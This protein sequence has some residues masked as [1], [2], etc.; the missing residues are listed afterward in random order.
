MNDFVR[1]DPWRKEASCLPPDEL[2]HFGKWCRCTWHVDC[3]TSHGLVIY[4]KLNSHKSN[5]FQNRTNLSNYLTTFLNNSTQ[6]S[7][8]ETKA[9]K[10]S[11]SDHFDSRDKISC[12]AKHDDQRLKSQSRTMNQPSPTNK[13]STNQR[14]YT[15]VLHIPRQTR[16]SQKWNDETVE[17]KTKCACKNFTRHNPV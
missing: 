17:E 3:F 12:S 11:C 9:V 6:A 15:A 13:N 5:F 7:V 2:Q 16:I 14:I 1:K 10:R 4:D 8:R